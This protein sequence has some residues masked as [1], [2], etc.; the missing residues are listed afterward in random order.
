MSGR[1]HQEI[2]YNRRGEGAGERQKENLNILGREAVKEEESL[3][4]PEW[5]EREVEDAR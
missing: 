4:S 1:N 2:E 3:V 5:S